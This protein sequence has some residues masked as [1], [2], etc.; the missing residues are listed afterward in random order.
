MDR[1]QFTCLRD[2]IYA[3]WPATTDRLESDLATMR[4]NK[5]DT[6]GLP[7]TRAE[8]TGQLLVLLNAK[9]IQGDDE[10]WAPPQPMRHR[11][12]ELLFDK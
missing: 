9:A 11:K 12:P 3:E 7:Q 2:M 5:I 8:L 4:A 6:T 1:P 10:G